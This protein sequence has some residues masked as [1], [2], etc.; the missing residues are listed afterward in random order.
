VQEDSIYRKWLRKDLAFVADSNTAEAIRAKVKKF[1][2]LEKGLE[3]V[4]KKSEYEVKGWTRDM[5]PKRIRIDEDTNSIE[6]FIASSNNA[7]ITGLL[8]DLLFNL[9]KECQ[10][11]GIIQ[12]PLRQID[13][14]ALKENI[15]T[16][17]QS[18]IYEQVARIEKDLKTDLVNEIKERSR[19]LADKFENISRREL[20]NLAKSR[21]NNS[22][23]Q[24]TQHN[25]SDFSW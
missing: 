12:K 9:S 13:N 18:M 6:L 21:Q 8:T 19:S 3:K 7:A 16:A 20:I 5:R 24:K 2:G 11:R 23:V 10:E 15:I 4:R 22:K 14:I 17:K 1:K 25:K